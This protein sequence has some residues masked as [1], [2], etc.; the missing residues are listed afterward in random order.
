M[1]EVGWSSPPP[2]SLKYL[3]TFKHCPEYFSAET[4]V[5]FYEM[6]LTW[7]MSLPDG[8]NGFDHVFYFTMRDSNNHGDVEG[9]GLVKQCGDKLC[10]YSPGSPTPPPTSHQSKCADLG[11]GKHDATCWCT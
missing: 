1:G 11:C 3:P 2:H 9:F 5:E 10:K 8:S 6:V 7:D 4:L